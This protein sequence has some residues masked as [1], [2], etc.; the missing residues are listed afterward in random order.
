VCIKE[1]DVKAFLAARLKVRD[2][3]ITEIET[4][5]T[6]DEYNDARLGTLTLFGPRLEGANTGESCSDFPGIYGQTIPPGERIDA[7]TMTSIVQEKRGDIRERF[8]LIADTEYGTLMEMTFTDVPNLNTGRTD[9][10]LSGPY[11]LLRTQLHKISGRKV[12]KTKSLM[13]AAPYK[14]RR[15]W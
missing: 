3:E 15:G 4:L 7:K 6:R 13:M 14:M 11:T 9:P 8:T 12:V 5:V 2:D 10:A 1:Y